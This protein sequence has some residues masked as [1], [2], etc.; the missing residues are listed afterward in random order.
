MTDRPADKVNNTLDV[1][2]I[3]IEIFK[4]FILNRSREDHISPISG[5]YTYTDILN[6]RVA[7]LLIIKIFSKANLYS[8]LP[9]N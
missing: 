9:S 2:S 3:H 6:Y 4:A 5:R 1:Y 7:S 8:L